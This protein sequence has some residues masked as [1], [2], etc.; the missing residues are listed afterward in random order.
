MPDF[1]LPFLEGGHC[2]LQAFLAGHK[3]TVVMFW[4]GICS[5]CRRYDGYLNRLSERYP[6]GVLAVAS[7]QNETVQ[8][9]RA[10]VAERRLRFPIVHD[11][12]RAVTHAWVVA[13]TPRVFL[14][15]PQRRLLYRGAIDNF[16]YPQD[17]E[18]VPYLDTAIEA[19]LAGQSSFR[20][21]TPSFGC[22]VESVFYTMPKP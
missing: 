10:T 1:T 20:A 15:D 21:E 7:R 6:V 17:P 22:P 3:A 14:L 8:M 19:L 13:Q 5:H 4:S 12:D 18:F 11:A 9:L 16:K 2:S